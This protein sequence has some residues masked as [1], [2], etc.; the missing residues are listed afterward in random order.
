[1]KISIFSFLFLFLSIAHAMCPESLKYAHRDQI[2]RLLSNRQNFLELIEGVHEADKEWLM[3]V[4]NIVGYVS[5]EQSNSL[6]DAL[7]HSLLFSTN[8]SLTALHAIDKEII[9]YGHSSVR[10][11]LGTDSVCAYM[12]N[13]EKYDRKSFFGYYLKAKENLIKSGVR[14]KN[15][16]ELMDSSVE[17]T[18]YEE[19]IGCLT[20]G[21]EKYAF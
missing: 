6:R 9:K 2:E 18:L 4:P 5:A 20:W 17:E 3:V 13:T 14:G 12:I 16:L 1:M 15:C 7:I 19:K 21:K 10:D 8:E 11:K